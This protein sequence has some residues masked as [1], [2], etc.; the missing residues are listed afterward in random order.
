MAEPTWI[1]PSCTLPTAE[2]PLRAAEFDELLGTAVQAVA[3]PGPRR[4]TL[5]LDPTP[6][7]AAAVAGLAVRETAC[8]SFFTFALAAVA[9][10]LERDVT[11]EPGH[12]DILDAL[13][14][15]GNRDT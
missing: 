9:G 14:E 11:V 2:R 8:C 3:R 6:E 7:V 4:L 10:R 13:A 12:T 15:R 5:R 1:P